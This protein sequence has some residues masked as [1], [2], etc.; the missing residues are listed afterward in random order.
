[1]ATNPRISCLAIPFWESGCETGLVS[2]LGVAQQVLF[3][4]HSILHAF[5]LGAFERTHDAA[6]SGSGLTAIANITANR[7]AAFFRITL[8]GST[9]VAIR[10]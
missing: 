1:M 10:R 5:S 8:T 9:R 7:I 2:F 6:G 3:A 4:Q